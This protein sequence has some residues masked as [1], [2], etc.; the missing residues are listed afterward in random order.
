MNQFE[1]KVYTP[2][3]G[4][5]PIKC[6]PNLIAVRFEVANIL[7]KVRRGGAMIWIAHRGSVLP[8]SKK[9]AYQVYI[10]QAGERISRIRIV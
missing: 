10:V 4:E 7:R 8:V 5:H 9:R 2:E 1:I 3:F 6:Q